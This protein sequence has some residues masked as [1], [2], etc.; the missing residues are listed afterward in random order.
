ML[1]RVQSAYIIGIDAFPLTVEVDSTPGDN[2]IEL[3]GLAD[4]A[5]K[6]S[7]ERIASALRNSG[8]RSPRGRIVVN[9]APADIP[10]E[11]SYLDLPIAIGIILT[12]GHA[13]PTVDPTQVIIA[14]ELALDGSLRHVPGALAM[15]ILARKNKLRAILVPYANAEEAGLVHDVDVIPI[16]NINEAISY[17]YTPERF[18]P[19]KTNYYEL[20]KKQ[21]L[22]YLDFEDVK[23]QDHAKR[24]LTIAA[25]GGH[26]VLMIGP[27]GTGKSML[28]AR[29]PSI[30]PEMTFEESLETTQIY[31]VFKHNND[32]SALITT[33]PFR[34]PHHTIS[35]V[36]LIGGGTSFQPGEVSLAHNGVL[37]LDELPE[38]KR[39]T[40]E[41]LRQPLEEGCVHVD[42]AKYK[43]TVPS[44][45]MLVSAMNPCPCGYRTDRHRRCSCSSKEVHRYLHKISGPLLDRIDIHIEVPSLSKEEL[46]STNTTGLN[47]AT[48]RNKV[49]EARERQKHRYKTSTIIN[50]YLDSKQI[51]TYCKLN[52][53]AQKML[54]LALER[55]KF[56]G[57]TYDKI[58]R[59]ARTIADLDNSETIQD[60]HIAEAI[61]YRSVD[62]REL[63]I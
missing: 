50:A 6:E 8:F 35:Q 34:S 21:R 60:N 57:R 40:L 2:K 28:A 13:I 18:T 41:S 56:S 7:R 12:G 5:V 38:F 49:N 39:D 4:T 9:L 44:R 62:L 61:Q 16:R 52:D 31:S 47:S 22:K 14:G 15:A 30:L 43:V 1:T 19:H 10:K 45:F 53:S 26:N 32:T 29:I 33:R 17:L 63:E 27:P 48:I 54:S 59:L 24:A 37:F 55:L 46:L 36:G 20:F 3:V 11:G 58:L 23:G 51:K 25:A 42:R